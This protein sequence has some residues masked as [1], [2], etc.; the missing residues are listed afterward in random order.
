MYEKRYVEMSWLLGQKDVMTIIQQ[1]EMDV[2]QIVML[3]NT[4]SVQI[5]LHQVTILSIT[6]IHI[7]SQCK[8]I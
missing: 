3:N 4:G 2:T 5:S 8:P 1:M 7:A 6:I